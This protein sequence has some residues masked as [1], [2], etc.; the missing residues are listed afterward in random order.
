MFAKKHSR[1]THGKVIHNC[2]SYE[3]HSGIERNIV[4]SK[5]KISCKESD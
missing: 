5:N 3:H 4:N 1:Y 2:G